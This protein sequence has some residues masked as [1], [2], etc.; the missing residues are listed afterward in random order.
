MDYFLDINK[1]W[2]FKEY[3]ILLG[4]RYWTF[5]IALSLFLQF[6][7]QTIVETGCIRKKDD[8]ES[9]CSTLIFGHFAHKYK[10]TFKTI[11]ISH[12]N[13]LVAKEVCSRFKDAIDFVEGDSV[14][15]L[16]K[17]KEPIDLLYLDSLD[18][19]PKNN[20]ISLKA[21]KHQL[22]E[23]EAAGLNLT[24]RAIVLL[25]DNYFANGGKTKLAKKRL[26]EEGFVCLMDF[27]QSLWAR[28][29]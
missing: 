14:K 13:L 16:K 11:D 28:L 6:G 29:R 21:Q 22:A 23:I 26:K 8:W 27:E 7:G 17:I 15:V 12:E 9:G 4:R 2:F 19:D 18:C 24:R 1:D 10:K 3:A 5:K 25:D 20:E